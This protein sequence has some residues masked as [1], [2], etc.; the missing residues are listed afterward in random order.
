MMEKDVSNIKRK[1]NGETG[2]ISDMQLPRIS[3]ANTE[4]ITIYSINKLIANEI[5][6]HQRRRIEFQRYLEL[7]G[8][9][10]ESTILQIHIAGFF[11]KRQVSQQEIE[12]RRESIKRCGGTTF[13]IIGRTHDPS[14][15]E[16]L[17]DLKKRILMKGAL[18]T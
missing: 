8:Y 9:K 2:S 1:S 18:V 16:N 4:P 17:I 5:Y 11:N 15:M 3:Y 6:S 7:F 13:A 10:P 14:I 12:K